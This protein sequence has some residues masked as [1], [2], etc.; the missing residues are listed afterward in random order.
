MEVG[1][2]TETLYALLFHDTAREVFLRE[3]RTSPDFETVDGDQL[4]KAATH[5]ILNTIAS[6]KEFSLTLKCWIEIH[7]EDDH[8]HHLVKE[9]L[10]S[11]Y[12]E[13]V[14]AV[15]FAGK[16]ICIEEGF[17]L[18]LQAFTQ[19][20]RIITLARD[21]FYRALMV[22]L[23]RNQDPFFEIESAEIKWIRKSAFALVKSKERAHLYAAVKNQTIFGEVPLALAEALDRRA[24]EL[25]DGRL[26]S[27]LESNP[28][29]ATLESIGLW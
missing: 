2:P 28:Y 12:F 26:D 22:S 20:S 7:P 19:E 16:G 23:A 21:E 14:I 4:Q 13:R 11:S 24:K 3:G 25:Q 10:R 9:F 5:L 17:F 27:M 18:F 29:R 6:L 1:D 15:P 8:G